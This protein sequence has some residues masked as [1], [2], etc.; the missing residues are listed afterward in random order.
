MNCQRLS[1][2]ICEFVKLFVTTFFTYIIQYFIVPK[3][4]VSEMIMFNGICSN[5]RH[6]LKQ[7]KFLLWYII[8]LGIAIYLHFNPSNSSNGGVYVYKCINRSF[9]HEYTFLLLCRLHDIYK[10]CLQHV[11]RTL[12]NDCQYLYK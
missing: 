4:S 11:H 6:F 1:I 2:I 5:Q 8:N 10:Q 9:V 12:F 7:S 3:E